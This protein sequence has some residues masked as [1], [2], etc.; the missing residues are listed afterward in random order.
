[1]FDNDSN[2]VGAGAFTMDYSCLPAHVLIIHCEETIG[3]PEISSEKY[4]HFLG[5]LSST[6]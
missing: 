6:D 3:E 4:I 2:E 1:M 5:I